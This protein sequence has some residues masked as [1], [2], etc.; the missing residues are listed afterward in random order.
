VTRPKPLLLSKW[1]EPF[2]WD[3][4]IRWT[5]YHRKQR[6]PCD[7]CVLTLHEQKGQGPTPRQATYRRTSGIAHHAREALLCR[8]HT[9]QWRDEQHRRRL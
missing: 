5:T 6:V 9:R 3:K 1:D 4:P 2:W 8:D 7:D